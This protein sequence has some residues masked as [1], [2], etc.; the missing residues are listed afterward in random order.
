MKEYQFQYSIPMK[1]FLI[2]LICIAIFITSEALLV[3]FN[4]NLLLTIIISFIFASQFFKRLK[5]NAVENCIASLSDTDLT[6]ELEN[7]IKNIHFVELTS[8]KIYYGRAGTSLVL[9]TEI[10]NVKLSANYM[11]CKTADFEIFCKDTMDAITKYKNGV[12]KPK[13]EQFE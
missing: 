7:N 6:L 10:E 5:R 13:K 8:T 4:G 3:Y 1:Q 11:F 2:M 12:S 9:K